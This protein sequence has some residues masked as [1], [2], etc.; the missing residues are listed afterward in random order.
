MCKSVSGRS[1]NP[2]AFVRRPRT[3]ATAR[4]CR[5]ERN[6]PGG[7][8]GDWWPPQ[9]KHPCP[10]SLP[11]AAAPEDPFGTHVCLPERRGS[12]HLE[13]LLS[14]RGI[15]LRQ[16]ARPMGRRHGLRSSAA[17]SDASASFRTPCAEGAPSIAVI[18][19]PVR[20]LPPRCGRSLSRLVACRTCPPESPSTRPSRAFL[21]R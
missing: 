16:T 4:P 9:S 2:Q 20:V 13:F 12:L 17:R 1:G 6:E 11:S 19:A 3:L 7:S 8:G 21:P 18:L 10:I 14:R 5:A 15:R